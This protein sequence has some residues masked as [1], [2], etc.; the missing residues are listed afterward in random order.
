MIKGLAT[1]FKVTVITMYIGIIMLCMFYLTYIFVPLII[2][3][4]IAGITY[5]AVKDQSS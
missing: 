4:T 5:I 3:G 2:M 1:L